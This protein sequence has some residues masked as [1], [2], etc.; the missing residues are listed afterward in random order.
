METLTA[1]QVI[2]SALICE[3]LKYYYQGVQPIA[4]QKILRDLARLIDEY[5]IIAK[6]PLTYDTEGSLVIASEDD[7]KGEAVNI[8]TL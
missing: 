8:N 2:D 3:A 4:N 5:G 1:Q 6:T 7:K